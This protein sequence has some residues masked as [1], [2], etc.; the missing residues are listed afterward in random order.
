MA[1]EEST[2][3]YYKHCRLQNHHQT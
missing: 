1:P 3:T 2:C